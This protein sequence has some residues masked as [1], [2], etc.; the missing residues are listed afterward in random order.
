MTQFTW[1]I[2]ASLGF[3][4][5]INIIIVTYHAFGGCD[6]MG[7]SFHHSVTSIAMW[8]HG[9][10][11]FTGANRLWAVSNQSYYMQHTCHNTANKQVMLGWDRGWWKFRVVIIPAL[12]SMATPQV[13]I[14][15]TCGVAID[16]KAGIMVA[17][18]IQCIN[19][20]GF[21]K[22]YWKLKN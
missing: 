13:V 4:Q 11:R 22:C 20:F 12:S 5:L 2:F 17:L 6:F 21:L 16:N 15:T 19:G 14:M 8:H 3:D 1:R 7:H 18:S 9:S 10:C